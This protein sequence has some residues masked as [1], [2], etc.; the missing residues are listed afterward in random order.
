MSTRVQYKYYNTVEWSGVE[1]GKGGGGGGD[2]HDH[3]VS[4]IDATYLGY[5]ILTL[6]Y[7]VL[8]LGT[9]TCRYSSTV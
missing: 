2:H 3:E 8:Y 6:L 1:S 7:F 5:F 4:N 9:N